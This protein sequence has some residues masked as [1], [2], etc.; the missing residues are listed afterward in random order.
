MRFLIA[1]LLVVLGNSDLYAQINWDEKRPLTWKDFGSAMDSSSKHYANTKTSV[2]Y[3][4]HVHGNNN[5][6]TLTFTIEC[7]FLPNGSWYKH[8]KQ[9]DALLHHEQ[10][11]FDI[12]ELFA[13]KLLAAFNEKTYTDNYVK[14]VKTIYNSIA[15]EASNMQERYDEETRFS[16]NRSEQLKWDKLV[17]K[18]LE[19]NP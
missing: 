9:T 10:L 1:F 19:Q 16:E 5:V 2:N 4:Y 6:Y 14:E 11:H 17:H 3:Q 12:Q 8:Y 13:R 7:L 15:K 18:Q